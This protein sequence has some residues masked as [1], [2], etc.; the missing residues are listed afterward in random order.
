MTEPDRII[1]FRADE[2]GVVVPGT[3]KESCG[4][5]GTPVW[6]SPSGRLILA[7][8]ALEI[9]CLPCYRPGEV[10]AIVLAPGQLQELSRVWGPGFAMRLAGSLQRPESN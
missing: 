4:R 2:P 1:C 7:K 9:I 3:T 8:G 6:I 5:C 10:R